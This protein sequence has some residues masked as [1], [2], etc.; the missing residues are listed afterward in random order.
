MTRS[1]AAASATRIAPPH[2]PS[3]R[4]RRLASVRDAQSLAKL[5]AEE[6][7]A[8]KQFWAEVEAVLKKANKAPGKAQGK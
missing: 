5:P 1:S 2:K 6:Q 3:L 7:E 4:F 8:W